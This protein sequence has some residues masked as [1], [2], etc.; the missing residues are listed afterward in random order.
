MY[1]KTKIKQV[2]QDNHF[3][4]KLNNSHISYNNLYFMY[5]CIYIY[6]HKFNVVKLSHLKWLDFPYCDII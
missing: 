6:I 4:G 1:F 3:L 5:I 2:K